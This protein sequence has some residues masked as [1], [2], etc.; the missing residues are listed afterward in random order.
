MYYT[1]QVLENVKT[2]WNPEQKD[3]E[4]QLVI[5]CWMIFICH[6]FRKLNNRHLYNI[7]LNGW[8]VSL[9]CM[10]CF[11]FIR[12][13]YHMLPVS[14]D[15]F[16][17]VFLRLVYHMLLVS[18]NCFCFVCLR[19]VYHM[20]PVSLNCFCFVFIRLV[21][22]MLPVSL[23]FPFIDYH[24]GILYH[25]FNKEANDMLSCRTISQLYYHL[26]S[27]YRFLK[28]HTIVSYVPHHDFPL[29]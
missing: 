12:L 29:L 11:V 17:F 1:R 8:E 16:C 28:G 23:D 4:S 15:C 22:H 20:L 21:Y 27:Q 5:G 7:R 13:V 24:F 6:V 2:T 14:L 18:L 3:S 26:R 19:L 25:L 10:F 9:C